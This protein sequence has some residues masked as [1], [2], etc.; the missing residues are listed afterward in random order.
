MS[1]EKT[2]STPLSPHLGLKIENK[3]GACVTDLDVSQVKQW[4]DEYGV[5]VFRGFANDADAF[6]TFTDQYTYEFSTYQGGG[7]RFGMF[8]RES[9]DSTETILTVTGHTQG[10][11]IPLHGEMYY[12]KHRPSILWFYCDNPPRKGGATTVCDGVQIFNNLSPQTQSFFESN[13]IQ[14]IRYL[15][16]GDWQTA[17][18]TD[19]IDEMQRFCAANDT[20]V[21]INPEDGSVSTSFTTS[22][23]NRTSGTEKKSFINNILNIFVAEWAFNS[24]WVKQNLGSDV[25]SQ[26]PM[27]VRVGEGTPLPSEIYQEVTETAERLTVN[28]D[29][30]KGDILMVDNTRVMHG[31]RETNDSDRSIFVRMGEFVNGIPQ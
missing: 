30:Q 14:Y 6:K 5:L 1:T 15:S 17:F 8:N 22:A 25:G 21:T 10:F 7:F 11:S 29:W 18:Q 16:D 13:S 3:N 23:L 26:C 9:V 19:D 24:G 31:R 4:L 27:V 20:Q 12:L 2:I 28:M